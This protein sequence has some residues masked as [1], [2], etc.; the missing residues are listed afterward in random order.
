MQLLRYR[1]QEQQHRLRREIAALTDRVKTMRSQ[2]D[3]EQAQ[4]TAERILT[5]DPANTWAAKQVE[6]LKDYNRLRQERQPHADQSDRSLVE[7]GRSEIPWWETIKYPRD[8]KELTRR[9]QP[10]GAGELEAAVKTEN[11]ELAAE[12]RDKI[13]QMEK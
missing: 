3:N 5:L 9:R 11:Y 7:V 13:E 1:C 2:G 10:S 6:V 12:L 4:S 8:W